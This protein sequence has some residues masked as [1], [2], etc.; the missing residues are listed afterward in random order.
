MKEQEK[1]RV[2]IPHWI[3][4]NQEH[5]DEFVNWAEQAGDAKIDLQSA[6]DAVAQANKSLSE[7]LKK[8]GG[9]LPYEIPH[10][11]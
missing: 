3:A 11:H 2:L 7:A 10:S 8:L 6:A 1:L 9:E 5:A 4:H